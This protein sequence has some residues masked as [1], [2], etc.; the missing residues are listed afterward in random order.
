MTILIIPSVGEDVENKLYSDNVLKG[1]IATS[2]KI[3]S[4]HVPIDQIIPF[5]A[6]THLSVYEYRNAKILNK[7]VLCCK[8][9]LEQ[10]LLS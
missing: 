6:N 8:T 10:L 2:K 9:I 7:I 3:C 5:L 1:D 4:M